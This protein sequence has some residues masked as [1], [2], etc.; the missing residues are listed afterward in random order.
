M[1]REQPPTIEREKEPTLEDVKEYFKNEKKACSEEGRKGINDRMLRIEMAKRLKKIEGHKEYKKVKGKEV[2]E[3]IPGLIDKIETG[4]YE[5]CLYY[6]EEILGGDGKEQA[7]NGFDLINHKEYGPDIS[8]DRNKDIESKKYQ[9]KKNYLRELA[10]VLTGEIYPKRESELNKSLTVKEK[11][12]LF[13]HAANQTGKSLFQIE[14]AAEKGDCRSILEFLD[15]RIYKRCLREIN[16]LNKELMEEPKEKGLIKNEIKGHQAE[17]F[18]LRRY[19][20]HIL[21]LHKK[22]NL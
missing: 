20:R 17:L 7:K 19:R 6:I 13:N 21:D 18:G 1:N 2:T 5:G 9:A 14:K 3:E 12:E 15:E 8:G 16:G 4:N 11:L 10:D 22:Y